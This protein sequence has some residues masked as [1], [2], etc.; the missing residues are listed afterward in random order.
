MILIQTDMQTL[1]TS[2]Q[3]V[4][5]RWHDLIQDSAGLQA[6]LFFKPVRY[7]LPR[8]TPGIRNP[9]LDKHIWPWF[10]SKQAQRWGA[11]KVNKI[12]IPPVDPRDD[13]RFLRKEANWTQ[14]LFQQPPRSCI[15]LVEKEGGVVHG[16]AYTEVKVRVRN[17]D[18]LRI[19]DLVDF[20]VFRSACIHPLLEE[21]LIWRRNF[22]ANIDKPDWSLKRFRNGVQMRSRICRS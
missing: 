12:E 19:G 21:G 20:D 4:C 13:E 16:T 7:T 1:L 10:C 18:H 17:G 15:G 2:A 3:R 5:H 14:M 11:P 6:D 9:L 22:Y 8:G